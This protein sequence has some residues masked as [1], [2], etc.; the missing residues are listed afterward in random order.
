MSGDGG[1]AGTGGGLYNEVPCQEGVGTGALYSEVQCIMG[2]GH[3]GPPF[4]DNRQTRL[5]TLPCRNFVNGR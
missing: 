4:S 3:M 2:N 5:K 1:G